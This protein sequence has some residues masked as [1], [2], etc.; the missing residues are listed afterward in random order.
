MRLI[1]VSVLL[2]FGWAAS[3]LACPPVVVRKEAVVVQKQVVVQQVIVPVLVPTYTAAYVPPPP[4]PVK[5]SDDCCEKL[6]AE[7]RAL[8]AE[9]R[10]GQAVK[11]PPP[12]ATAEEVFSARCASCHSKST[13]SAKGFDFV[14]LEDDGKMVELTV[15]QKRR[16]VR[17]LESNRMPK[18]GTPL[19]D[20]EKTLLLDYLAK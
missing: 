6:L 20:A 15:Q 10:G 8:R 14:L 4:A 19:S 7:I 18:T 12:A 13:A 16:V 5:S 2:L 11:P 9:L 1:A 3:A 17:E